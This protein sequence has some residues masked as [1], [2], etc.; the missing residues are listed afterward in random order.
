MKQTTK[1]R[2]VRAVNST[3]ASRQAAA[4]KSLKPRVSKTKASPFGRLYSYVT[5]LILFMTTGVW[6]VFGARL[7]QSNADQL[8]D[9]HFFEHWVTFQSTVFPSGHTFL[10]KWPIFWLVRLSGFSTT[11]FL[12]ATVG[13]TLLTVGALAY[14]IYRIDRRPAIFGTLMLA[15]ASVLLLVPPQASA[16]A[17]LPVNMAMLT[18]RN[19]EYIFYI[20]SLV[21]LVK[22]QKLRDYRLWAGIGI[23]GLLIASDKLFLSLSLGG[24]LLVLL[25]YL[26]IQRP[27]RVRQALRWFGAALL[28]AALATLTLWLI[29]AVGLTHISGHTTGPFGMVHS[30]RSLVVGTIFAVLGIATNFGANPSYDTGL[31]PHVITNAKDQLLSI[32]GLGYLTNSA[33]LLFGLYASVQLVHANARS[34]SKMKKYDSTATQLSLLLLGSSLAAIAAFVLTNHYYAADA[35]YLTI[36]IFAI[37]VS[38]A[39]YL[40]S[41]KVCSDRKL[42]LIVGLLVLSII[43][44]LAGSYRIYQKGTDA[45]ADTRNRNAIVAGALAN[46]HVDVLVGDYWRVLPIKQQSAKAINV[47]PLSDCSHAQGSLTSKSWELDLHKHSFAYLLSLDHSLTDKPTCTLDQVVSAFGRS[48]A[49]VIVKGTAKQPQEILIYYDSGIRR[50]PTTAT[51]TATAASRVVTPVSLDDLSKASCASVTT[52]N[53]VAHQDDDLLFMNPDVSNE[54]KAKNCVVSVYITAGDAGVSEQY[55]LSRER[56]AEAAYARM[57]GAPNVLWIQKT[58]ELTNSAFLTIATPLGNHN[59]RLIFFRLPDGN[60]GGGGFKATGK[61]SLERLSTG[62]I[63]EIS[64]VDKQST[65]TAETLVSAI[66]TLIQ[67]FQPISIN[68]LATYSPSNR[69]KD[70]SDHVAV[71]HYVQQAYSEL[72]LTQETTRLRL[73]YGY[74][75]RDM[76]PNVS[77]QDLTDKAMSFLQ[78]IHLAHD[79]GCETL[80]TCLQ[81]PTYG[82][83]LKRQYNYES[84]E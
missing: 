51:A 74:S 56:G 61:E 41:K 77:A 49:S 37:A 39:T 15:L 72:G 5:L 4:K 42:A 80:D 50:V 32:A 82:S 62:K 14:I 57:I 45:Q 36:C 52:M 46:H 17:L 59:I 70:H 3:R 23:L 6:A 11:S 31:L 48:N 79:T 78:Y 25:Y 43:A 30:F 44:G 73:Y 9:S 1:D 7:Q 83:Y 76:P 20:G 27:L 26:L 65:Y 24:S 75:V 66:Q 55:W 21:L 13:V 34:R 10:L 18:T 8:V 47:M 84:N 12:V 33:L 69:Y 16:G 71:G 64:S 29:N 67:N 63:K 53:I 2:Q 58:V 22:S 81:L 38:V 19:I 28:A 60:I 40:R 68:T 35:R 54:I